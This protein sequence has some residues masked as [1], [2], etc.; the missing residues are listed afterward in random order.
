MPPNMRALAGLLAGIVVVV[1]MC[2]LLLLLSTLLVM[3]LPIDDTGKAIISLGL[4]AFS[5][6]LAVW[7][8]VLAARAVRGR[9]ASE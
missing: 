1:V 5:P 2:G 8:G 6:F 7:V 3:P 9:A 4:I